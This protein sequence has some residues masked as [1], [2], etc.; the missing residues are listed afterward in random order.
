VLIVSLTLQAGRKEKEAGR[1][2]KRKKAKR[3]NEEE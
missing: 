3:K 1:K 2:G